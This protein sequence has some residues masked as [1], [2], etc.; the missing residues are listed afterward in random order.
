MGVLGG[1][2]V[3]HGGVALHRP[4][5][6]RAHP[7]DTGLRDRLCAGPNGG[8][9]QEHPRRIM[10]R[11][12]RSSAPNRRSPRVSSVASGLDGNRPQTVGLFFG[13]QEWDERPNPDQFMEN[14]SIGAVTAS[15]RD[16]R[17]PDLLLVK[18]AGDPRY[19]TPGSSSRC[20][21]QSSGPMSLPEFFAQYQP[22]IARRSPECQ[23]RL[24]PS[25][26]ES[27]A[28]RCEVQPGANGRPR[29]RLR[30]RR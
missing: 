27:P 20:W 9:E 25:H 23:P 24:H 18:P 30:P 29:C 5:G 8:S 16:Q 19:G 11:W 14:R 13:D 28:G 10:P 4:F 6:V 2:N 15:S 7:R 1:V 3:S 12:L 22:A 21:I 26:A 17:G